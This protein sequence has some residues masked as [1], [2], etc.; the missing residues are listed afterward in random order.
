MASC[1]V[2]WSVTIRTKRIC[3]ACG[4]LIQITYGIWWYEQGYGKPKWKTSMTS[5]NVIHA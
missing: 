4:T 2:E 1:N 3:K 5:I